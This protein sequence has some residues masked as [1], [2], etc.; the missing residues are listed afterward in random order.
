MARFNLRKLFSFF[1]RS[2]RKLPVFPALNCADFA[3]ATERFSVLEGAGIFHAHVDVA[4]GEF[5]PAKLF[6]LPEDAMTFIPY[7]KKFF[8]EVH[9]MV[10]NPAPYV[11][12]W[13]AAGAKRVILHAETMSLREF[14]DFFFSLKHRHPEAEIGIALL[15]ETPAEYAVPYIAVAGFAL[16]LAVP[17][18]YSGQKFQHLAIEKIEAIRKGVSGALIEVDGGVNADVAP[19]IRRAGADIMAAG[20]FL[21][22]SPDFVGRYVLLSEGRE[23]EK[24]G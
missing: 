3:S 12:A 16:V 2:P 6:P 4:D 24:N 11:E 14:E 17:P 20:S 21:F 10:K 5:S 19:E 15:P 9:C 7:A 1:L 8:I 18:G 13:L 23:M 22:D